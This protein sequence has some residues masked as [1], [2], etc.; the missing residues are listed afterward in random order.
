V[1]VERLARDE[2]PHD[3]VRAL[4]D[5]VDAQVAEQ[6]LERTGASPRDASERAVS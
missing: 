6:L 5:A 3:L 2:Q 1:L 4:E